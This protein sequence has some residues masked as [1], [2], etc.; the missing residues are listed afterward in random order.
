MKKEV[1]AIDLGGTNLRTAL[2]SDNKIIKYNKVKTPK[3]TNEIVYLMISEV[4]KL[5]TKDVKGIGI[6]SPGPLKNGR[7]GGLI[8]IPFFKGPGGAIPIPLTF[9]IINL[10]TSLIIK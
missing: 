8:I 7:F 2:I 9:F 6:A 3:T 5:I 1:I 4:S 10:E